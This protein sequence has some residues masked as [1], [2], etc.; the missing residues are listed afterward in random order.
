[1]RILMGVLMRILMGIVMGI[2]MVIFMGILMVILMVIL[3][4][5]LMGIFMG[6]PYDSSDY[7]LFF[8]SI[9][10]PPLKSQVFKECLLLP[11]TKPH[12]EVAGDSTFAAG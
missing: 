3:M 7:L 1:M 2:L 10:P 9:A 11:P 5:I 12:T 6:W 8:F 4:G